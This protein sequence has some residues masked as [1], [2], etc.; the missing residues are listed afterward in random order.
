[1]ERMR[2]FV[3]G[4][5]VGLSLLILGIVGREYLRTANFS[6]GIPNSPSK[7]SAAPATEVPAGSSAPQA[8]TAP[9][10]AKPQG[11]SAQSGASLQ[12][13]NSAK[14]ATSP[15]PGTSTTQSNESKETDASLGPVDNP[16]AATSVKIL[17]A[18]R[19]IPKGTKLV[20]GDVVLKDVSPKHAMPHALTS[21][22]EA[23]GKTTSV[24]LVEGGLI[25]SDDLAKP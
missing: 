21:V 3:I 4:N 24:E 15:Q 25:G 22:E 8:T 9:E 11:T 18:T 7:S 16:G 17:A 23:F 13:A 20:A 19:D 1:M 10:S 2:W 6:F 12:P 14:S 5:L